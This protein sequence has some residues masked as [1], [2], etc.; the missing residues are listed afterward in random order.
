MVDWG[1]KNVYDNIKLN[2]KVT[3]YVGTMGGRH[4][5]HIILSSHYWL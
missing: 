1:K 5:W 3:D 2:A 4:S